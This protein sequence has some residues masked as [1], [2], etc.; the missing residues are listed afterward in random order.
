MSKNVRASLPA[1]VIL[2]PK[3]IAARAY[4]IYI[5][6]GSSDG[7]ASEDWVRAEQELHARGKN[8]HPDSEHP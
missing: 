6:R 1:F 5:R 7:F 2:S 4:E 8:A 3:D